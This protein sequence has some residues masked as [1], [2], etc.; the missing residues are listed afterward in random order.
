MMSIS[1]DLKTQGQKKKRKK[2]LRLH[3]VDRQKIV[4]DWTKRFYRKFVQFM[5]NHL[6]YKQILIWKQD[7]HCFK[8]CLFWEVY[9]IFNIEKKD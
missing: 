1:G 3:S 2:E 7:F 5:K 4:A 9:F 6:K 8:T